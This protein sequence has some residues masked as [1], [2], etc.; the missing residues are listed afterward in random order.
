[1]YIS[2]GRDE[3]LLPTAT[4][5]PV[6]STEEEQKQRNRKIGGTGCCIFIIVLFLLLFFLIP[7]RPYAR[8][9][10]SVV[11]FNPYRVVQTY[12]VYNYNMYELKL[13]DF[14]MTSTASTAQGSFQSVNGTLY[15]DSS[16]FTVPRNSNKDM[17]LIYYWETNSAQ[18]QAIRTQC[19]TPEGVTY[20]T[21]GTVNMKT[22]ITNFRGVSMGPWEATYL[23]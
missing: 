22:Q 3:S 5:Y 8:F 2:S 15:G 16:T 7:R 20:T 13:S 4:A 6:L 17:S 14:D 19:N 11:Y 1:M 12:T 23:C 18:M 21:T 9:N 10:G